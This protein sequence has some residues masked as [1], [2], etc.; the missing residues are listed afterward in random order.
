MYS[1][2]PR[3]GKYDVPTRE[4][5]DAV[6]KNV[7]EKL[8]TIETVI[9]ERR[10]SRTADSD[11]PSGFGCR[12]AVNRLLEKTVTAG[13]ALSEYIGGVNYF[14]TDERCTGCGLCERV[15]LSG[16][17]GMRDSKPVWSRRTLCYMC[18]A[19]INFCPNEAVQIRDIPGVKSSSRENG[20]YPHPY[21][22]VGD[23]QRQKSCEPDTGTSDAGQA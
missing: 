2:E 21:A 16:K 11:N 4:N 22:T 17:I 20:R 10:A 14:Y 19:C 5:I 1:N 18:F 6:E 12:P 23:M 15:C 3:H 7:L 9:R 8:G 13:L